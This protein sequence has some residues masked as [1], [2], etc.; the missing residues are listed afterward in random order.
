MRMS[1]IT[2]SI[3]HCTGGFFQGSFEK[4]KMEWNKKEERII[5]GIQMKKMV[6][7]SDIWIEILK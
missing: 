1:T 7:F 5:I 2:A 3:Q 4:E 6:I